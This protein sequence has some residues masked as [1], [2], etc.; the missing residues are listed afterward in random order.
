MAWVM[1]LLPLGLLTLGFPVF[2][3]LIT[4]SVVVL[5]FFMDV[6]MTIAHLKMFG[7]VDKLAFLAAPFFIFAGE[8]MSRG[9]LSNR[10]VSWV[11][12]LVGGV[13]GSLGITTVG[14]CAFF[15][16]MS[17][18]GAATTAAVGQVLYKPLI[19]NGYSESFTAGVIA[20]SGGIAVII[21]P[22][23]AMI[24]YGGSAEVSVVKLFIAGFVPGLML[25]A[26]MAGYIYFYASINK[27][28][29][30]EPFNWRRFVGAT[31][32][33]ILA[34]AT[35]GI[36]LGGIY[37]GIFDPT[38]AGAIAAIYAIVV[39]MF[40]YGDLDWRGLWEAAVRTAYVCAQIFI[41]IAAAGLYSWL[42]TISGVP[43]AMVDVIKDIGAPPWAVLMI[44]NVFLLLVG[45]LLDPTSAII[46]LTPLLLPVIIAIDV[47]LIH[48]GIIMVVNLEIGMFT[49]PFGLN[50]FI[51]QS[52]LRAPLTAIYRGVGPF[53]VVNLISLA[54]VTYVPDVSLALTRLI[55]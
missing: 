11:L 51:V 49:P 53:I 13:R 7:S 10:I 29:G 24:L 18:S 41:I 42:L 28:G 5:V 6:P 55:G 1:T 31:K 4:T 33:G 25:T 44:I 45:C 46:I 35:P 54:I 21:P 48:F 52:V 34:L 3:I 39:T 26:L 47:D 36:I 8:L 12:S 40:V 19:K 38:E 16:A 27:V 17:G 2:L 50:I 9:G 37:S 43:Q 30:S 15:G 14:S 22:S 20:S 23:I 32:N